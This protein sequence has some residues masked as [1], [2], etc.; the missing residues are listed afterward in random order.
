MTSKFGKQTITMHILPNILR[1]KG[2]QTLKFCQ[3]IKYNIRGDSRVRFFIK[4]TK[5]Y[6]F[7]MNGKQAESCLS[8]LEVFHV[9][10]LI[11]SLFTITRLTHINFLKATNKLIFPYGLLCTQFSVFSILFWSMSCISLIAEV[12]NFSETKSLFW[13]I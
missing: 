12:F 4:I 6:F 10:F 8:N 3:L 2:N 9:T 1:S 5:P 11:G 7:F 13:H